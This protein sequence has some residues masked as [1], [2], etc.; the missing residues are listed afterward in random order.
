[1]KFWA[2]APCSLIQDY[3]VGF[4]IALIMEAAGTSETSENLYE[5]AWRNIGVVNYHESR[6]ASILRV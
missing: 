6:T 3:L 4:I 2:A 5:A 1:M